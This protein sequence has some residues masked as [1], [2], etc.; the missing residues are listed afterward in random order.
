VH[1]YSEYV[2]PYLLIHLLHYIYT[3]LVTLVSMNNFRELLNRVSSAGIKLQSLDW[4]QA[5]YQKDHCTTYKLYK[6]MKTVSRA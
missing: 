5:S 3:K 6:L 2:L 4:S 1:Y